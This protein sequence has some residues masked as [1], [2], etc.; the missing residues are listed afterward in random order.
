VRCLKGSKARAVPINPWNALVGAWLAEAR[1]AQKQ[2]TGQMVIAFPALKSDGFLRTIESAANP[3]PASA[4]PGLVNALGLSFASASMLVS[5]VRMLDERLPQAQDSS[6]PYNLGEMARRASELRRI[7][8]EA[9]TLVDWLELQLRKLQAEGGAKLVVAEV[10][11][12]ARTMAPMLDQLLRHQPTLRDED[13]TRSSLPPL[14]ADTLREV[15]RKLSFIAPQMTRTQQMNWEKENAARMTAVWGVVAPSTD[16]L[17][18]E[19]NDWS[20]LS[21]SHR[22][23][24]RIAVLEDAD[25]AY[26]IQEK[27]RAGLQA[28]LARSG[29]AEPPPVRVQVRSY[30][31]QC[32]EVES[33]LWFDQAG[34]GQVSDE[35]PI[36]E[37]EGDDRFIRLLNCWIYEL[38]NGK[39]A[40]TRVGLMDNYTEEEPKHFSAALSSSHVEDW[41]SILGKIHD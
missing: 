10:K 33:L 8:P 26:Y 14:L 36:R 27:W 18:L 24:L 23:T 41:C 19:K 2:T 25:A 34:G 37:R 11:A 29:A 9:D 35:I 16:V 13:R 15:E 1:R 40:R 22:P 12:S 30:R 6:R 17:S 4:A 32:K 31:N 20:F 3:L 39:G 5:S 38:D 21:N 28:K 7:W